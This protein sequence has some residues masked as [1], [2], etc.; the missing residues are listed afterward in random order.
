MPKLENPFWRFDLYFWKGCNTVPH[1]IQIFSW[2]KIATSYDLNW[3]LASKISTTVIIVNFYYCIES[4]ENIRN[5]VKNEVVSIKSA[6]AL[7]RLYLWH[8]ICGVLYF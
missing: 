4:F 5:P 8:S 3:T 6:L 2:P 1:H 7:N